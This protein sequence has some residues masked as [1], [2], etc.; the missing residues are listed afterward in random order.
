MLVASFLTFTLGFYGPGDPVR[1]LMGQNWANEDEYLRM[2]RDLGLDRPFL[3]QYLDYLQGALQADLGISYVRNRPVSALI[4]QGLPITF[5]LAAAAISL[6]VLLGVPLGLMAAL[7]QNSWLDRA[8]VLGSVLVHAVP[9]Y[10]LAPLLL[11]VLVLQLEV[12]PVGVGWSGLFQAKMVIPVLVLVAGPLVYLVRQVR[13]AVLEV[14]E[15]DYV[16]TAE[17]KGLP[18]QVVVLRHILPN[19][20]TPALSQVGVIFATM[21]VSSLFVEDIFG[22]PGFGGLIVSGLIT[23]DYP[24]L[25]GTV[26]VGVVLVTTVN[27]ATDLLY[28]AVDPRIRL[29]G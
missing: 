10:V 11:V 19:A 23:R 13:N 17:A 26:M 18:A 4:G 1:T 6:V 2:K 14:L 7:R 16:R 27:L 5:Q 25:M 15:E 28:G 22:L 21:L 3:E 20:I 8:V 12:L 9:A 24:L 29:S